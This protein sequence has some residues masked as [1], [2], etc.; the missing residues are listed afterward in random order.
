M[1]TLEAFMHTKNPDFKLQYFQLPH[2]VYGEATSKGEGVLVLED[3]S[4][5]GYDTV[6][7]ISMLM[8]A[9][10]SCICPQ[11]LILSVTRPI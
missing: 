5:K 8:D 7:S 11:N 6:D 2:F 10:R 3:V 9:E 1:P 4:T